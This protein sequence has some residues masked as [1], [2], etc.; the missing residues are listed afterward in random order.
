MIKNSIVV[1]FLSLVIVSCSPEKKQDPFL[2]AKH[3]VGTLTDST[4]VSELELVFA[5]DSVVKMNNT[6]GFTGQNRDYEVYDKTGQKLL[7]LTPEKFKDSSATITN[8][9]VMDDRF[10]TDKNISKLSTFKDIQDSYKISNISNLIRTVVISVD[11]INAS[12]TIDKSELP[13]NLRFDMD[14]TI[15]A[16]QIP[17]NAKIKYFMLHW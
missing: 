10:K 9:M 11:E 6:D 14:A 2:I 7:V 16:V 1:L 15:E 3:N 17:D 13:A 5:N 4:K 12:F 8:I